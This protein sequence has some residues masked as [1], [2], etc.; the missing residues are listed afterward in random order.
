MSLCQPFSSRFGSDE[1]TK[2][3]TEI[4][5]ISLQQTKY[6]VEISRLSDCWK[7]TQHQSVVEGVCLEYVGEMMIYYESG[8]DALNDV[9]EYLEE[10]EMTDEWRAS[11]CAKRP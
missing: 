1:S 7:I 11:F 3:G 10:H 6:Y 9:V 2:T 5:A 4:C 8:R